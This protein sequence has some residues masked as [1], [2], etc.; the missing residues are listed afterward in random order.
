MFNPVFFIP[1]YGAFLY[2]DEK[3]LEIHP[4]Y[5]NQKHDFITP[6]DEFLIKAILIQVCFYFYVPLMMFYICSIS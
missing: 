2:A 4:D 1:F 6:Y 3:V 5:L